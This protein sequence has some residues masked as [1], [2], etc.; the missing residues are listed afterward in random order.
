[1]PDI[2]EEIKKLLG[3]TSTDPPPAEPPPPEPPP[4]PPV[5]PE[6]PQVDP[7]AALADVLAE[8][9]RMN[10]ALRLLAQRPAGDTITDP[11]SA[12]PEKPAVKRSTH[13][14]AAD[15]LAKRLVIEATESRGDNNAAVADF[16]YI[17]PN[18]WSA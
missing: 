4:P 10:E 12:P 13:I 5:P 15:D 11:T 14:S 16:R 6:T 3:V 18:K 9:A 8:Q 7:N 1:M 2:V 17:N